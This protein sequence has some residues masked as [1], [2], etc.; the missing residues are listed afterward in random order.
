ME[1]LEH[2]A[3][4]PTVAR[5]RPGGRAPEHAGRGTR[6][7]ILAVAAR[8]FADHGYRGT[9]L[10][11]VAQHVGIQKATIFHHFASKE[12]LYRAVV[13]QGRGET[14][15]VV[16][17]FLAGEGDWIERARGMIGAYVD[18]VAS[19][20]EQTKILLRQSLGDAPD[21]WV[22]DHESDRLLALASAFIAEGQRAGAFAPLDGITLLLG[23]VGM[24]A[25][26]F[27]SAP[28]V[29]PRWGHDVGDAE[30]VERIRQQVLTVVERALVP[31]GAVGR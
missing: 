19:H 5:E 20:P 22:T 11:A 26:L 9:R 14:E 3:V 15:A 30:R 7:A 23:V 21:G 12:E 16:T 10:R 18:L 1:S 25:F 27:A 28:I 13:D 17:R 24:V 2:P 29:A 6:D 4:V 31:G 8:C